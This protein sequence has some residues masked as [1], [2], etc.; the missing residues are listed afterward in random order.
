MIET[1]KFFWLIMKRT[2]GD[3]L[4]TAFAAFYVIA[5]L[6]LLILE[7]ELKNVGDAF[8]LG[9]NIATSIGLGDYTVK[10]IAARLTAVLLGIYGA[11]I[12]AYIPGLIVSY[13]T[14]KTSIIR[15]ET[16]RQHYEQLMDLHNMNSAQKKALSE[17]I[18]QEQTR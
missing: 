5:C 1:W 15:D 16:I 13:Y 8:W 12:V 14:E 3:K 7:P 9:F 17:Q 10:T 6:L 11:V 4:L 2:H 18:H